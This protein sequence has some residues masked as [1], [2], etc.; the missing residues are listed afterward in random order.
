MAI[1]GKKDLGRAIRATTQ[2]RERAA[3]LGININ[4]IYATTYAIGAGLAGIAGSLLSMSFVIFPAM[5]GEYLLLSFS[6]VVLGGM[7]YI[8]G[9]LFGGLLLGV[10]TSLFT[11]YF[12][13]GLMYVL[14]FARFISYW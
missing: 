8:P 1:L 2:N 13:A 6:I 12:S 14:I 11:R 9:A 4:Q 7:G 10:L 5:G 3:L